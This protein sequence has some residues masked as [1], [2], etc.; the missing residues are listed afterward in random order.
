[1][2]YLFINSV[3]GFG[4]TGRIVAEKCRELMAQGHDCRIAY[5]RGKV[6]CDD[7]P[8]VCIGSQLDY[9]LH[10]VASRIFDNH[11]FCSKAATRRFLEQVKEYDPDV[12]WLHNLHGYYIHI[13]LLFDYLRTCGKKICWT[14]HD[15]WAFTGH[16]AYFD[17]VG[18]D[19]WKTG[20]HDCPQKKEYPAS[21]LL[22][23]SSENFERK[24]KLFTGIPNM[25]I[26]T[27]SHWLEERVKNS[28]LKEYPVEVVYNTVNKAVFR[29]TPSDF[30]KKHGL[31][32]QIL[33]LGVASVW[34]RRKGLEDF[35]KLS[36]LL[37]DRFRIVLVG[38]TEQQASQMPENILCLPRTNSM[39]ELAEIYTAADVHICAGVEE[40]FG[41][42]V[43]ESLCCGTPVIVYRGTACEE[44]VN[45][46]GGTAVQRGA[47]HICDELLHR[48]GF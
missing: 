44:V 31:E 9:Q 35:V 30:R 22:D 33:I 28:F 42:T 43:L 36:E 18:C 4:S 6:N 45:L 25:T 37:D 16:C 7:I 29:P 12:I 32:K 24:R 39:E 19:R 5:G 38:L 3:A 15:C 20:C 8:T 48:F 1:M 40:T 10:G 41:M 14:L 17:Y 11:G 46:Y 2:K 27:V 26:H 47:Q 23:H 21:I 13:G 34:E